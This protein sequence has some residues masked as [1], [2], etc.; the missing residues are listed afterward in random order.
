MSLYIYTAPNG[1]MELIKANVNPKYMM[2]TVII[3]LGISNT[4]TTYGIIANNAKN[5]NKNK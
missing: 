3:A 1:N 4:V 2:L 5:K